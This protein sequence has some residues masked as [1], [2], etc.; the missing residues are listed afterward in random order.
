MTT[1]TT[2]ASRATE[3]LFTRAFV[4]LTIAE[5]AYFTAD[6]VAIYVLPLYVTG[7]IGSDAAGAGVAF[8]AFAVSALF[9]RP[10]AGRY[11]DAWG[12]RPVLLAGAAIAGLGLVLTPYAAG[13]G[14]VIA[15][16]LVLG[17]AEAAF[18]VASFAAVADLAPPSRLGEAISYNSLGLYL[19]LVIGPLLGEVLVRVGDFRAAWF[20]AAGLAVVAALLVGGIGETRPAAPVPTGPAGWVHWASVPICLAFLASVVAM[21]SLLAFGPLHATDLGLRHASLPIVAYGAVVVVGRVVFARAVDR[22]PPLALGAGA[23]AALALGATIIASWPTPQGLVV[24]AVV[25]GA[26]MAFSTPAFFAAIFARTDPAERGMASGTASA[27][28]DL[29]VAAGPIA[30]GFGAA[31]R[32]IPFAFALTAVAA[33]AGFLW[34]LWLARPSLAPVVSSRAG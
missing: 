33:L 7:P 14:G 3:R 10:V 31:S 18:M 19:G 13:L 21:A 4:L 2:T 16:R 34:A 8:G 26:G 17:V 25:M 6:G 28:I 9:L 20:G 29:G 27:F 30:L 15:L 5:L 12:R 24:G 22:L 1:T 11:A 23:L 32:G